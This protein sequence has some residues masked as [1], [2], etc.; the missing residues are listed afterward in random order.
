MLTIFVSGNDTDAGKTHVLGQFAGA[1]A[2]RG[3][4]TQIVKLVETGMPADDS[5]GDADRAIV[6]ARKIAGDNNAGLLSAF[7]LARYSQPLAPTEAA[8]RDGEVFS[9][10]ALARKALLLPDCDVR[11]IEGA[12]GLAVPVDDNGRDWADFARDNADATLLVVENRLGAICQARFLAMYCASKGVPAPHF[13]LNEMRP[14]SEGVLA[15][16]RLEIPKLGIP[17]IGESF[18]RDAEF[19]IVAI[20]KILARHHHAEA[21]ATPATEAVAGSPQTPDPRFAFFAKKLSDAATAGRRREIVA[22]PARSGF[23]DLSSNDYLA[24]ARDPAVCAGAIRATGEFGASS[25]ASPLITGRKTIHAELERELCEWLGFRCG[26]VWNTGFAANSCV[27]GTLPRAGDRVFADRLIHN[28][29]I[30]GILKSGAQFRRYRHNDVAHLRE[31]L[32]QTRAE[33]FAG[34]VYVATESVF[35]MDGDSPDLAA[36][37]KLRDEFG[38]VFIVDEAHATGWFGSNGGGLVAALGLASKV[39][40]LVGTL[41]KSLGSAGAYT[42]FNDETLRDFLINFGAEFIFSTYLPPSACGAALAAVRRVRNFSATERAALPALSRKWRCRLREI[43][44]GIPD[45]DSAVIPMVV[46]DEAE[47]V[48]IAA[49]LRESGFRVGAIRPPTVPAGTAR[50][51]ISLN[52]RLTDDDLERFVVALK[53]ALLRR[54]TTMGGAGK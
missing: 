17:I 36:M 22:V 50:L 16:N 38:F 18:P 45:G 23:V 47:T 20:E 3:L 32:E 14:Q 19:S 49:L 54:A 53:S 5:C 9:V 48:Q 40:I 24:L 4:R 10:E 33:N 27:L 8:R 35:S 52:R 37:A 6:A 44:G 2:S 41:G 21:P 26:L 30:S 28:S 51:R 43:V 11:L 13:W 25:S 1:L 34:T 31:M 46:G 15:S 29:M 42:L 12:G 7:R 39:D